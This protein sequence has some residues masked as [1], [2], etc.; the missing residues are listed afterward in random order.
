MYTA[1][2]WRTVYRSKTL[3]TIQVPINARLLDML[4]FIPTLAE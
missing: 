2:H 4:H 1:I 3:E